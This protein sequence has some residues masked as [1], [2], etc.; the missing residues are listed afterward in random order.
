MI[1]IQ[2]EDTIIDVVNKIN[3]NHEAQ[4]I[5]EFP[6]GHQILHNYLSLKILKNKAG[7]KRITIVTSDLSSKKIWEGIGIHYSIIKDSEFLSEKNTKQEILKHNFTFFEYFLFECKKYFRRFINFIWEKLWVQS[8][9]YYSPYDTVKN[10]WVFFLLLG[11]M[12]S[13]WMLIFIFYFAVNKTYIEINPAIEIRTKAMNIIYEENIE[14]S[15]LNRDFRIP[16]I[17]IQENISLEY[18]HKTTGIDNENTGRAKA[19][20]TFINELREEQVFRPKTRLLNEDGIVFETQ[21]WIRIPWYSR[22]TEWEIVFG[23]TNAIVEA[24][25]YDEKWAFI[26][27][28]W[29][30]KSGLFTLPWLQFSRDKIYAKLEWEATG[31]DDN[32]AYIVGEKDIENAKKIFEERL[33]KEVFNKLKAKIDADNTMNNVAYDILP[34]SNIISYPVIDINPVWDIQAWQK[35]EQFTL[36]WNIQVQTYTYNTTSVISLL[37]NV[38]NQSL[39]IGTDRLMGIDEKSLRMTTVLERANNPLRIK[40]TTEVDTRIS[41]DFN[42]NSNFYNQRLKAMVLGLPNTEAE[43]ILLNDPKVNTVKISNTPFFIKQVSSNVDNIILRI[44]Q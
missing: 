9:K 18:T 42:D 28:R 27:S 29:N 36:K 44:K 8:L 31:W 19:T 26:G 1:K 43:N 13:L 7:N 4:I 21:D 3:D 34:I 37:R 10:S 32:I 17:K 41:F 5:L 14:E 25:L 22:N 24:R 38:V 23:T 15:A 40:A 16:I 30:I 39:L 35:I 33:K 2:L 12:V 20:V 11:V 6:F